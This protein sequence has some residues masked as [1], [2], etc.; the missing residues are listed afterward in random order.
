MPGDGK[1]TLCAGLVNRG[2]RLFSDEFGLIRPG[3]G[4]LIPI[5]RPMPLKNESIQVIRTFAPNAVFGPTILNTRK[6]TVAHVR[7]PSDSV[8]RAGETA[9]AGWIVFPRWEAGAALQIDAI[10]KADAFMLMAS[11]SFNYEYIGETAFRSVREIV[12]GSECFEL[13]YSDLEAAAARLTEMA[14]G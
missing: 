6:G 10:P 9:Q 8:R 5:P 11:N 13:T 2:W 12:D 4:E 1:T 14:D 7:P 3:T